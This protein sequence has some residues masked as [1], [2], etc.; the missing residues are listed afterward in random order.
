MRGKLRWIGG[1]SVAKGDS[2]SAVGDM[3]T[4]ALFLD[5]FATIDSVDAR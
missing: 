5:F 1:E 3:P 4:F 2:R